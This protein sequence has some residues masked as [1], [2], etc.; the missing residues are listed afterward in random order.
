MFFVY[1]FKIGCD[2]MCFN[3]RFHRNVNNFNELI[4]SYP[5]QLIFCDLN[6]SIMVIKAVSF[7]TSLSSNQTQ[8]LD[9]PNIPV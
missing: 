6:E 3:Y 2:E 4:D 5:V 9:N 1:I 8:K 7:M